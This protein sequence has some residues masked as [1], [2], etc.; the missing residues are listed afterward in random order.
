M[1]ATYILVE[2]SEVH[3]PWQ[4]SSPLEAFFEY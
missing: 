3:A 1:S 2:I 4:E